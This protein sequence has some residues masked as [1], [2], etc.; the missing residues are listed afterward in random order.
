MSGQDDRSPPRREEDAELERKIRSRRKFTLAEAIGRL[1]GS[2]LLKGASPVTQR[3]QAE[4][5]IEQ[6]LEQNLIDAEGALSAVL[7]RRVRD[8][9]I[10]LRHSYNEPLAAL[11]EYIE[12]VSGARPKVYSRPTAKRPT[13][14]C[15]RSCCGS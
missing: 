3:R 1:G 5:A 4:I 14:R 9:E 15:T 7:L 8:S 6:Y 12:R 10:L 13:R 11:A 2:D